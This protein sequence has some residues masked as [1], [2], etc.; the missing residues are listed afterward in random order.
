VRGERI[1]RRAL[2]GDPFSFA[3][4]PDFAADTVVSLNPKVTASW[5]LAGDPAGGAT[6]WTRLHGAA[7]TGIRPPDAFEIGFTNNPGLEPER[8]RSFDAGVAQVFASGRAQVDATAFFNDYD[9]LIVAVGSAFTGIS[10]WRTDNIAN[11]RARGLEVS[12]AWRPAAG[13]GLTT[14]YTFLSTE[15]R[16]VDGSSSAPPPYSVGDPLLRRPRHQGAIDATWSRDRTGAFLQVLM[17]GATLDAEPAFGP[18][19][20]LYENP[21][22]AVAHLGAS[23]RLTRGVWVQGRVMNLFDADYEEI[24]G[25]PAPG[26][27]AYLGVRLAAGR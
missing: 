16:A 20:G 25:Y 27:T 12:G 19:G 14:T 21:G 5:M 8:S 17:R 15:I 23:F 4:R 10:V 3:S 7:G 6:S 24:L 26:R 9:D 13:L 2:E 18:T 1:H 11:A 22:Y